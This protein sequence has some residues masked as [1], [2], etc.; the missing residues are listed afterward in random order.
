LTDQRWNGDTNAG[1]IYRQLV[2]IE[3]AAFLKP[4]AVV[5]NP[6]NWQTIQLSQD[7]T[8][9]Y[10][11]DSPFTSA[12]L[13]G[14]RVVVTVSIAAGSALVGC[15]A[16]AAQSFRRSDL[17]VEASQQQP[18]RL[19]P[20][21]PD[22]AAGRGAARARRLPPRPVGLVTGWARRPTPY[23]REPGV[24]CARSAPS[25]AGELVMW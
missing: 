4:D 13:W 19:L 24:E 14:V 5:I 15:F 8:R 23:V 1:A 16:E 22:R 9:R 21:Q 2:A 11:G 3:Q 10:N 18:Q 25:R 17:T 6:A 20:T 12:S 7:S